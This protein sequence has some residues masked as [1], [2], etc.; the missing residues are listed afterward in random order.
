MMEVES[1]RVITRTLTE[2][3]ESV[4]VMCNEVSETL[5]LNYAVKYFAGFTHYATFIYPVKTCFCLLQRRDFP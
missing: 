2:N 5:L 3:L 4:I 1:S